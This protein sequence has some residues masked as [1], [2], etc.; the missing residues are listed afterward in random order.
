MVNIEFNGSGLDTE[1]GTDNETYTIQINESDEWLDAAIVSVS[2]LPSYTA[3]TPTP[4]DS[5]HI[6]NGNL[7]FRIVVNIDSHTWISETVQG[8]SIDNLA[9]T[10]PDS[11]SVYTAYLNSIIVYLSWSEPI[12]EDFQYFS[13]FRDEEFISYATENSY[14]DTPNSQNNEI[15]YHVTAT[16]IHGNESESSESIT[17]QLSVNQTVQ[18]SV[19]WNWFSINVQSDDMS[20]NNVLSSLSAIPGDFIKSQSASAEYYDE[21]GWYGSL[22]SINPVDMYQLDIANGGEIALTGYP[23]DPSSTIIHLTDGWNWIGY[24][25]QSSISVN[26]ALESLNSGSG[27]IVKSQYGYAQFLENLGFY[28]V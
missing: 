28:S 22:S 16:D 11:V 6:S 9:P 3:L 15:N 2:G 12:D 5:S 13:I 17:V 24:T 25:P 18:A 4:I 20:I 27:D 21:F 26:E 1:P 10:A 23:I 8:Y 19:G 14:T 7:D